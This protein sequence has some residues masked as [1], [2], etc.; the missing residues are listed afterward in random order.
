MC[1]Y[2]YIT[3]IPFKFHI[4]IKPRDTNYSNAT[5]HTYLW[6]VKYETCSLVWFGLVMSFIFLLLLL[7][8]LLFFFVYN[9]G[10]A[11]LCTTIKVLV[12]VYEQWATQ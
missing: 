8:M 9:E 12:V 3:F 7:L 11:F 1:A 2:I 10:M 6:H 5:P 4:H